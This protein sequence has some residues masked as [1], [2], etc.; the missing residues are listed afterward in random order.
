MYNALIYK[1]HPERFGGLRAGPPLLYY[2][3]LAS[4]IGAV[5]S[6]ASGRRR[7]AAVLGA[8]WLGLQSAFFLR[9]F[10]GVTHRPSHVADLLLTSV[11]IPPLSIYWRLRGALRYRVWLP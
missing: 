7:T 5:A 11:L 10:R 6:A 8:S 1:K 9:R 3:I 4:G 2:G